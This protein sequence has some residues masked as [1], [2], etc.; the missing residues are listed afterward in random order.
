MLWMWKTLEVVHD[1]ERG[2]TRG[3]SRHESRSDADGNMRPDAEVYGQNGFRNGDP[4]WSGT[5]EYVR[6][7]KEDSGVLIGIEMHIG[8]YLYGLEA[9]KLYQIE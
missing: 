8:A 7:A 1:I 5:A 4:R 3:S 6:L 9:W 2:F